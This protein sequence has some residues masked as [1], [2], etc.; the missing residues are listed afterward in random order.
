MNREGINNTITKCFMSW[1]QDRNEKLHSENL[2]QDVDT[3]ISNNSFANKGRASYGDFT[4][5]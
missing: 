2:T 3:I 5:H 1:N 4:I